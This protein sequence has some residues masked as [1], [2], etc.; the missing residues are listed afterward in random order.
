MYFFTIF[1]EEIYV[2]LYYCISLGSYCWVKTHVT[3]V[4]GNFGSNSERSK[5]AYSRHVFRKC[6]IQLN[7]LVENEMKCRVSICFQG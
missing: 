3:K 1:D 7:S 4:C 5:R 2:S 6:E